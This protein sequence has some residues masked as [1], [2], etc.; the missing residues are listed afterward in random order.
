[1]ADFHKAHTLL[2]G[3]LNPAE[4]DKSTN[5]KTLRKLLRKRRKAIGPLTEAEESRWFSFDSFCQLI[6]LAG[7]NQEDSG[8]LYAIHAHLNH[9]CEPN[10]RVS[11]HRPLPADPKVR[12][13]PKDFVCPEPPSDLANRLF[14]ERGT[15]RLTMIARKT[16]HP[17]EEL[18]IPYVNFE[19]PRSKRR[20]HLREVYGFWCHCVR[21]RREDGKPEPEPQADSHGHEHGPD[22]NHDHDHAHDDGH[23]HGHGHEHGPGCSH[24]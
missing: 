7:L 2:L 15:N 23:D 16:I 11:P 22:C 14:Q 1:M 8:G 12:N 18:T 19:L 17:G 3:A 13:L 24:D 20:E 9:D 10:V 4:G 5:A 6:G 21:C